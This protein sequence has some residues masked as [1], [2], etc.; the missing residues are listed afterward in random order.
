M[1]NTLPKSMISLSDELMNSV[2]RA[3]EPL[4]PRDHGAFLEALI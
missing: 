4:Q 1:P 2:M 3:A